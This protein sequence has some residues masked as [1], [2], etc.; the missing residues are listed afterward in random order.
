M[1]TATIGLLAATVLL[2]GCGGDPQASEQAPAASSTAVNPTGY[3][4]AVVRAFRSTYPDAPPFEGDRGPASDWAA[5]V[6][7]VDKLD[8]PADL[9]LTHERMVAAFQA[10]VDADENAEKVCD[11]TPGPGGPCF[12]AVHDAG[13]LWTAALDRTYEIP[14]VTF[15]RLL[16]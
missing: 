4:D 13:D 16:G 9:Q 6:A 14:G 2:A 7:V 15:A 12:T 8:V 5:F 1:R 3:G 10:Y 11:V